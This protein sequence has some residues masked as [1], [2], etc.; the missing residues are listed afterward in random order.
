MSEFM[1]HRKILRQCGGDL[2]HSEKDRTTELSSEEYIINILEEVTTRT[3]IGA[4]R[5]NPKTRFNKPWKD[6]VDK[7]QKENS[8]NIRYKSADVIIKCHICQRTTNLAN[9]CPKR[10]KINEIDIEKEPDDEKDDVIEEISDDKS[11]IFSESSKYIYNINLTYDIMESDSHLPQLRNGQ[12]DLSKIQ[13]AQ[14]MKT[15]PHREKGY[16]AVNSCITE[17]IM[18]N[19]PTEIFLDP[20][21]FC[22]C[23]GKFLLQICVPNFEYQ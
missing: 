10:V 20:G 12:L 2:E 9:R 6:S 11:S 5:V 22:A 23:V 21:A 18:D 1:I 15:R 14:L 7:N 17:V 16:T 3:Q 8:N 13:Y 19:K 4:S